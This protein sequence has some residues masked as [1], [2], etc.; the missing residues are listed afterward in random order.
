M[1]CRQ[2]RCIF[3]HIPKVAGQSV[4]DFFLRLVGLTWKARSPLLLRFNGDLNQGPRRLAHLTA[5]EYISCGHVA[6]QEF[7]SFFKFSFVRNPWDRLV[8]EYEFRR[9]RIDCEF[10]AFLFEHFPQ[11]SPSDVY[12][13][14]LPQTQFL[15]DEG[16]RQL[17][18]F[19]GRFEQVSVLT[20]DTF[21]GG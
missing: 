5:S 1:V 11:P 13:H 6:E 17:V 7:N 8:S 4:E 10:K 20:F 3:V 9:R 21:G 14:I 16:G 2:Y 12:R 19:V 18:D 15:L